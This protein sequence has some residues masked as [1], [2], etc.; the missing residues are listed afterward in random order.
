MDRSEV[1]FALRNQS[2]DRL[3]THQAHEQLGQEEEV[4]Y[5]LLGRQFTLLRQALQAAIGATAQSPSAQEELEAAET[6]A[7]EAL[8]EQ[9]QPRRDALQALD[10]QAHFLSKVI[11]YAGE[12][13]YV[14]ARGFSEGALTEI[15]SFASPRDRARQASFFPTA[16][17]AC[18]GIAFVG[19]SE[20][21]YRAKTLAQA[22]HAALAWAAAGLPPAFLSPI[23]P[24][25]GSALLN[26]RQGEILPF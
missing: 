14:D 15:I 18:L 7:Y 20:R 8:D 4:A 6:M 16:D 21:W 12:P 24:I 17:N 25:E 5:A 9:F 19:E 26:L 2:S 1:L 22:E 11:L 23:S 13:L 3:T 10:G